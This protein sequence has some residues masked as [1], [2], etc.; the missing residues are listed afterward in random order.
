MR[1]K[2]NQLATRDHHQPASAAT[3]LVFE[4]SSPA[5]PLSKRSEFAV[6]LRE[7]A[8]THFSRSLSGTIQSSTALGC[9]DCPF[10]GVYTNFRQGGID[11]LIFDCCISQNGV[12]QRAL[13]ERLPA[14]RWRGHLASRQV[15]SHKS[16]LD[17]R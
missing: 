3:L 15:L 1:K 9:S 16:K 14:L 8:A 5:I 13:Y 2:A 12:L 7:T 4:V 11:I 10:C 17:V 6:C